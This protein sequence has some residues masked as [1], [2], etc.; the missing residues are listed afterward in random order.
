[1]KD[2]DL[3]V[4]TR[5]VPE[6]KLARG[7]V[8]T[9]VMVHRGRQAFEVEFTTFTGTTLATVTLCPADVRPVTG[10]DV[11]HVREVA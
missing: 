11:S 6:A 7:D 10:S 8:G 5:D 1:M 9:V 3:V 2:L 4:L